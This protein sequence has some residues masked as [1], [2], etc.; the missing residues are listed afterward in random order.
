MKEQER[1]ISV[2]G[3]HVERF[4]RRVHKIAKRDY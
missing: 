4:F 1:E 3:L 2:F